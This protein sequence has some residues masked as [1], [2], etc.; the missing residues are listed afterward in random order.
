MRLSA[1]QIHS[2]T[3]GWERNRKNSN[4]FDL[5]PLFLPKGANLVLTPAYAFPPIL[6]VTPSQMLIINNLN[7]NICRHKP[8]HKPV[9]KTDLRPA[10]GFGNKKD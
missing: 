9:T 4:F 6:P 10:I 1:S 2:T 5:R 7:R 3:L 8:S